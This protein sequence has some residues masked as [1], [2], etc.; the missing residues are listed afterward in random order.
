MIASYALRTSWTCPPS[1]KGLG[2]AR[3]RHSIKG[4]ISFL[5]GS[6]SIVL[7]AKHSPHH[8]GRCSCRGVDSSFQEQV[9][10]LSKRSVSPFQTLIILRNKGHKLFL[11]Q[12]V[13]YLWSQALYNNLK[14][15]EVHFLSPNLYI[16]SS[17]NLDIVCFQIDPFGPGMIAKLG[18]ELIRSFQYEKYP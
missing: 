15:H 4:S 11:Y 5:Y 13:Y 10:L 7:V 17:Q 18:R 8:N 2:K 1:A 9:K 6:S 3:L 16:D 14:Q 12:E